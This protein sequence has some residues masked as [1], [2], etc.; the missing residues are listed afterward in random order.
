MEIFRLEPLQARFDVYR[1]PYTL[2]ILLENV[3]RHEDGVDGHRE[4]TSRR[5]PA[6]SPRPS[7]RRRSPSRP[8][9]CCSRTSPACRR[10]STSR[11]CGTRCRTSAAPRADQPA[12][13]GRARDRPLGAGGRVRDPARDP[14][15]RGAR[16]RAES[17]ALRLPA[18]GARR[19]RRLQGRPA[20]DRDRPPGQPRVPRPRRRGPRRRRRSP[21]RSSGRTRT[22]R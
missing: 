2:R 3:L 11:R 22:R 19:L 7:R 16:V 6:G 1:L 12:A 20:L 21:T 5:S 9:A 18:L 14:P 8:A 15:E 4:P 10:S 17:R 13:S